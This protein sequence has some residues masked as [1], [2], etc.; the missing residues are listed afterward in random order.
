MVATYVPH[1][2][3]T[4]SGTL[5]SGE[6]WSNSCSLV[7]DNSAWSGLV[8]NSALIT[9]VREHIGDPSIFEDLVADV[10]AYFTRDTTHIC[11]D[12][13]LTRIVLAGLDN[14]GHYVGPPREFAVPNDAGYWPNGFPE[15]IARKV[16]LETDADLGRVKG[17]WY[18]PMPE[19]N[20]FDRGSD[21][22]SATVTGEVRDSTRQFID[23]LNNAPGLDDVA[24][25]VVVASQGRH[26]RDHSIRLPA[27]NYDVKRVNVGRRVDVQRRR[28]NKYSEARITDATVS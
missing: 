3:L 11:S 4:W 26:N 17:G 19:S 9:Y 15:Q 6:I 20:G 5:P 22:W 2:R 24:L 21:L 25:K 8:G 18:L 28:A 23:D 10:R 1:L 12:A 7:P 27:G 13:K 16:T 14:E